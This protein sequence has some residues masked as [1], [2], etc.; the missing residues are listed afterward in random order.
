M[1]AIV[2]AALVAAVSPSASPSATPSPV[3]TAKPVY[4]SMQWRE[5]G[6][7]L[8]GGR[9]A[10]VA[11]SAKNPNL[12][13]V[14]AAGG[15]VWK[16]TDGGETWN[17][18]FGTEPVASI[19]DV[20][21]DPTNDETVWVATGEG[22]PRNDVIPGAGVYK[23]TNGGKDWTATG[24]EKTRT[25]TRLLVD[26]KNPNHVLVAA[27][28]DTFAPSEDRGVYVTDDGG[29]TWT[30]TLYVGSQSGASDL[31]MDPNNP[32]IVY[33]GMWHF[34]RRPWTTESGGPD[35]GLY[36]STDGGKT[37]K[38]LTGHGLPEGTIGRIGLAVAPSNP[39]RVYATIEA[40]KGVLWRSDDAGAN[41]TL[42]SS[43]SLV[44]QRPFYFSHL[45]VDPSNPDHVY[46]ISVVLVSSRDGGKTFRPLLNGP[47]GDFHGMWIAPNDPKRLIV[48]ED[49][50]VGVSHD[51]G[52][53]WFFD[54]NLPIG[55]VYHV[56]VGATGNP[57]WV[58]G[59]WQDNNA[60]CGPSNSLDPSGILNKY[61]FNVN[62]G[63][64]EW[65]IP[66]PLDPNIFWSDS[67][68]GSVIVFDKRNSDQF[69]AQPYIALV[70]EQFDLRTAKY[71]FNWDS[72]IAFAPWDGHIGWLG[73]N[74]IFQT[75]DRGRHWTVISPDLTLN[76]KNHQAP[77]GGPIT[78]DVSSAE[79]Y[80]TI[81][82]IEGSSLHKGEIWVGTDDGQ[83][84]YT[85]DGGLHWKNVTPPS[86]PDHGEA[87]TVAPSTTTDGTVFV[88]I[89]RHLMG[90]YA[91][92][93]L[94]TR[95]FG[96][97]WSNIGKNLPTGTWYARSVRQDLHN[98]N[99]VYAGTETGMFISCD[100]GAS[101]HD[102]KNNL[103]TVAVR[104]IRYQSTWDDMVIAT[105]GR[106]LYIM[107]DLRPLQMQ[108]CLTPAQPFVV[109][110][111]VSYQYNLHGNDEGIYTDYAGS[112]PDYGAIFWYY[113]PTPGTQAPVLQ[114][115]DRGRVIRTVQ[116][117]REPSPFAPAAAD[118]KPKPKIPNGAG[119]QS[120]TWGYAVDGPVKWNGAGK[121]FK[122]PD[123]GAS[124][125]PGT[126]GYRMTVDGKTFSGTFVVKA[127]P[128]TRFTQA[129]MVA[130]Y[131]FSNRMFDKLSQLDVA[132][133]S[134]DDVRAALTKKNDTVGLQHLQDIQDQLT[135]N[136]QGFEDFVQRSGKLREDLMS[137]AGA[138]LITPAV[139]DSERRMN[140]EWATDAQAFNAYI[141]TLPADVPKP[142]PLPI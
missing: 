40:S 97:T 62:G 32:N 96:K 95:D 141:Q 4:Q 9:A 93:L 61:W 5:I 109:G 99:I 122:G 103:P 28:G 81:L 15:G 39:N 44:N 12:Y 74:V 71:R 135:A 133:N 36:K 104:D 78:H 137:M 75:K 138:G 91:P 98:A 22:N 90:D 128:A 7:A 80:N 35:D 83:V 111:R 113:Q 92:Y 89:D 124:V 105:H 101:W 30:K 73:G 53:S 79:N 107:D 102:F 26:P 108:A 64:G 51:G 115:F 110:P 121:F 134:L 88:S 140:A 48:A 60:W 69:L 132:L 45:A 126:Y 112:N 46:G 54:R 136:Y 6:P 120:F 2:L 139:L 94:V 29:K 27:L 24:L 84:Q 55:E 17:D 76:E 125:P 130:S 70:G 33:A 13:Y 25:I 34:Q 117:N 127:D 142:K 21:I 3:P 65:A 1:I 49:G 16:S 43:E 14:G 118:S 31:A 86:V 23:S 85:L 114:I 37:W 56:G 72:P 119:L 42:V 52:G 41:W 19:G 38:Q 67:Q 59:G 8:P 11:G 106:A 50:G 123:A 68:G 77:P 82:D 131:D 100:A 57:Y 129:E 58:C 87:E 47:H 66:D 63:D 18:V 10:N 20:V 116:G